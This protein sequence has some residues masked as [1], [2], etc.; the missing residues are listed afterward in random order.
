M[1]NLKDPKVW[2]VLLPNTF[3]IHY[4]YNRTYNEWLNTM[5]R[6]CEPNDEIF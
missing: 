1:I 2:D 3:N 5:M 4:T 6:V